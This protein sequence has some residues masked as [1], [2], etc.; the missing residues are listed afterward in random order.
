[1]F[2]YLICLP[3]LVLS[4]F[5][6]VCCA[7]V[8]CGI[9]DTVIV[10]TVPS[11]DEEDASVVVDDSFVVVVACKVVGVNEDDSRS[12]PASVS[13]VD[14]M[15]ENELIKRYIFNIETRF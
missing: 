13:V 15:T 10:E 9:G 4:K 14:E 1:M 6:E 2:Q 5:E 12:F 7:V 11:D 3:N 8:D